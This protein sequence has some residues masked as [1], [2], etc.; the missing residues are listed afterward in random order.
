MMIILELCCGGYSK[1]TYQQVHFHLI[2]QC[3]FKKRSKVSDRQ[4]LYLTEQV[5]C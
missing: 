2:F 1:P 3:D 4:L 5:F